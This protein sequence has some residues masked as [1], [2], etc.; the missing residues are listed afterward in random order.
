MVERADFAQA[1]D[2]RSLLLSPASGPD[3]LRGFWHAAGVL[4]DSLLAKQDS[5]LFERVYGPKAHASRFI[6]AMLHGRELQA[7]MLFSS[8]AALQGNSGQVNYSAANHNLDMLAVFR[9]SAGQAAVSTQ[10]GA[11]AEIGMAANEL[12]SERM[13]ASGVGL[14][15]LA[16]GLEVL[17]K[18]LSPLSLTVSAVL[19]LTWSK[20]LAGGV[21]AFLS[22]FAP[23][24]SAA[25]AAA[26]PAAAGAHQYIQSRDQVSCQTLVSCR[27]NRGVTCDIKCVN[28]SRSQPRLYCCSSQQPAIV[29]AHLAP[30]R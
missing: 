25:G 5:K 9:R 24:T 23:R 21:P 28:F 27:D 12:V 29:F 22:A 18:G 2:V 7:Y 30:S 20:V 3:M 10:W 4:S 1:A 17:R 26:Q 15:G 16:Q 8:I 19:V 11:W 14:I 6:H 13:K